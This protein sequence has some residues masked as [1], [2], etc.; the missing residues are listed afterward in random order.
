[1][2]CRALRTHR[3]TSSPATTAGL[4]A[5]RNGH[6]KT[7]AKRKEKK[8]TIKLSEILLFDVI[9]GLLESLVLELLGLEG[10]CLFGN[11][12]LQLSHL[13][14]NLPAIIEDVHQ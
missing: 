13:L 11:E 7:R 12:P 9:H 10:L 8:P 5:L 1:M 4:N 14:H 2:K 3:L 6:G